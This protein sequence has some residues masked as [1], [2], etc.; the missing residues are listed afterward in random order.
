MGR[1]ELIGSITRAIDQSHAI[2]IVEAT[3]N[4][5]TALVA[6]LTNRQKQIMEMVLLGQPSKNIAA[7]LGVSRRTVENHRAA[8]MAKMG[9]KSLP[10]LARIAQAAAGEQKT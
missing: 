3:R 8:I 4:A 9:A 10:E 7:D 5:A 1:A 2:R 6:E